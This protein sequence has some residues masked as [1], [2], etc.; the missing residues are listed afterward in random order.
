MKILNFPYFSEFSIF[1]KSF[2]FFSYFPY[3]SEFS[4]FFHIFPNFPYFLNFYPIF[5]QFFQWIFLSCFFFKKKSQFFL[6]I[7]IFPG[8][9]IQKTIPFQFIQVKPWKFMWNWLPSLCWLP[10]H[11]QRYFIYN[12]FLLFF[13]F[14]F[15]KLTICSM[16]LVYSFNC[17]GS[18]K[19]IIFFLFLLLKSLIFLIDLIRK[20]S[21]F[22]HFYIFD[23][24]LQT[25]WTIFNGKTH[26]FS[27]SWIFSGN[28]CFSL[29]IFLIFFKFFTDF[30][31]FFPDIF[32]IS[33]LHLF[34]CSSMFFF[35]FYLSFCM[36]FSDW[37]SNC[38]KLWSHPSFK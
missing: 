35:F 31:K 28:F 3:F 30:L 6:F 20:F 21:M 9:S 12:I 5:Q 24:M 2:N 38:R 36:P 17:F 29:I 34:L 32:P 26:G 1:F 11:C 14:S 18:F 10:A 7:K 19:I 13:F 15:F 27:I 16:S 25:S 33:L 4:I 37:P 23:E 22:Y 8:F